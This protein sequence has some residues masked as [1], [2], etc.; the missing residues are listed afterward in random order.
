MLT[1][2]A[3][4]AL[5]QD[6]PLPA[7]AQQISQKAEARIDQLRKAYEKACAEVKAQELKDLQR[8]H[9]AIRKGDPAGATA[10]KAKIDTLASELV[11]V[12]KGRPTVEQWIQGK[13]ILKGGNY[14]EVWEFKGQKVIGTGIGDRVGGKYMIE[15]GNIQVVWDSGLVEWIRIPE[16]FGDETTGVGRIGAMTVKRVK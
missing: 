16:T 4:F 12:A 1:L 5:A 8:V 14:G 2:C 3:L 6:P 10:V 15:N 9:E 7:D 13:W 11:V